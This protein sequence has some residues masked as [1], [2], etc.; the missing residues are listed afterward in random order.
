MRITINKTNNNNSVGRI[1]KDTIDT[2][3]N[4]SIHYSNTLNQADLQEKVILY[5]N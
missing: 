5:L 2:I 3:N 4:T 1:F